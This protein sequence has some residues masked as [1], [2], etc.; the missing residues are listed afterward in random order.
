M[1]NILIFWI[2]IPLGIVVVLVVTYW[3]MSQV[4][5]YEAKQFLAK[6]KQALDERAL[7]M[8]RDSFTKAIEISQKKTEA[9]AEYQKALEAISIA[10]KIRD[11]AQIRVDRLTLENK[12][13]QHDLTSA[14]Q[15]GSRLAKKIKV[16]YK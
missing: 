11:D 9:I 5:R 6:R 16:E 1:I 2:L 15:R 13:L 10:E 12:Q 7:S 3:V 14:R 4:A 8:E